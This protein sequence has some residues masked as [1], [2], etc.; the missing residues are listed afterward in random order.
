MGDHSL[1]CTPCS[2]SGEITPSHASILLLSSIF[3]QAFYVLCNLQA[4]KQFYIASDAGD[5]DG[6]L[7]ARCFACRRKLRPL[8]DKSL[9]SLLFIGHTGRDVSGT[10][11]S[12][13]FGATRGAHIECRRVICDRNNH[14][15]AH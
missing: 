10:W 9:A 11:I 12:L 5:V 1:S 15:R 3:G 7:H 8:A 6:R 4:G 14:L 13:S 2:V